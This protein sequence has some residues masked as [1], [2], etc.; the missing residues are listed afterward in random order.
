LSSL[1]GSQS[2]QLWSLSSLL[3]SSSSSKLSGTPSPHPCNDDKNTIILD[4][5]SGQNSLNSMYTVEAN[6]ISREHVALQMCKN[7][8][9]EYLH[10]A[11]EL[12][13]VEPT[14]RYLHGVV[15]FPT[16]ASWLKAI[17]KV[18]YL[19][20][21]L[22]NVKNVSKYFPES[23]ETQKGHM[24]GQRQG[25]RSTTVATPTEDELTNIPHQKRM[26]SSSW[27]TKSNPSCM[28]IKPDFSRQYRTLEQV[29]H[30]LMPC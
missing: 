18:N 15:G 20:W 28:L 27:N 10:N 5:P 9:Q 4:H 1:S 14:I 19:S 6:Q 23:K 17:C 2:M 21:P 22:I 24:R 8:H 13:S 16:R 7:Y 11:Y 29:R 26:T 25:V 12:P 3:L 30:D